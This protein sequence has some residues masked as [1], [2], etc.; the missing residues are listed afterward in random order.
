MKITTIILSKQRRLMNRRTFFQNL[1]ISYGAIG[2]LSQSL[3]AEERRRGGSAAT[4]APALVDPNDA[5]A[6]AVSYAAHAKD[7][8]D[9]NLQ[10][11][12]TGVKFKDQSCKSCSFYLKDKETTLAGKKVAP[13]QMPFAAGKV[14]L[15]DGWCSTWA[16]KA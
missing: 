6:K 5:A 7:V 14:V 16:K 13:C 1:L 11:D 10:V 4:A 3:M 12:R 8:K 2:F 15:A 9:K